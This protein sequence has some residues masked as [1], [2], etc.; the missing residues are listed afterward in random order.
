MDS[1]DLL[2]DI[3]K[4]PD[5]AIRFCIVRGPVKDFYTADELMVL[6]LRIVSPTATVELMI[7]RRQLRPQ[8]T[9]VEDIGGMQALKEYILD[10]I[11]M[12]KLDEVPFVGDEK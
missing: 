7:N 10:K 2:M 6:R 11:P 8:S 5:G 9:P 1:L 3:L 4:V 12:L